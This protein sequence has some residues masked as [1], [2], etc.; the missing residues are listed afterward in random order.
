MENKFENTIILIDGSSFLYRAYY[1]LTPMHS[2]KG[3][4]VQAVFGFCRMIKKIMNTFK[5]HYMALVWDSKGKTVRH[6]LYENYKSTRQAPPSDLFLQKELIQQFADLIS[7]KQIEHPGIEADDLMFSL[8]QDLRKQGYNILLITSDKDMGQMVEGDIIIFDPFK[9]SFIDA[10]KLEEKYGFPISKLVFYFALIGDSSDNIPGVRGIGPKGATD[11]V[12][13]FDSLTDLYNNIEKVPKERTRH[14]LLES[15]DD[16]FLSE[17]LF[18]LHY[19]PQSLVGQDFIF[20]ENKWPQARPLFE[21]LNFKSLLKDLPLPTTAVTEIASTEREFVHGRYHFIT[22]VMHEQLQEI[23]ELFKTHKVCALDTETDSLRALESNLL[24]I[25]VCFQASTAYYIPYGHHNTQQ[26]TKAEVLTALKPFLEDATIQ[27]YFHHA[28]YDQKVLYRAG[29]EVKGITF[30]TLIAASLVTPDWQRIGL[31][32]LSDFYFHE[33][34]LSYEEVVKARG[35]KN[36]AEV[37]LKLATDYAAGDAHQTWQLVPV[38]KK[39]LKEHDQTKLYYEIELPL[40]QVL[41]AM[42][43]EGIILDVSVL[44]KLDEHVSRDLINLRKQIIDLVGEQW[45]DINL[46]SSKQL[47]ELL[48]VYLHLAPVKKTIQKTGY[49]T[50]QEVLKELAKTHPVPSLVVKYRELAKLKNTYIDSLPEYINP[51]TGRIHTTFRQTAVATGRL[52]SFDPNLQNIPTSSPTDIYVRAAF[53]APAG[54]VFLSADYSQI[55]LRVLAYF[56]QDETLIKAFKEN[57]DIHALTATVLFDVPLDQVTHEQRKVAKRINFS[58]LY[59]LTPY[60]LSKDLDIPLSMAR[61]YIDKYM[62]QFPGI[63]KWM[64]QVIEETNQ[65]GYVT[66]YWGRRRYI[67]GIYEKNKSL[68]EAAR[69]IAINTKAQGTAAELMKKGMIDLYAQLQQQ[70]LHTKLVLQIHD[71]LLL[72]VPEN[73]IERVQK[74]V[75]QTLEHVV[76]WNIP[77]VI[78]T[79]IGHDWHEVTK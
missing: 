73:E 70:N 35:Y 76:Q 62:A 3:V 66:T 31:K 23:V 38:L 69:R 53:K 40:I 32:A 20:D 34:M 55:E 5:P 30:D 9:D 4:A 48:F 63:T 75:A 37:P 25:S 2:A 47:E 67:S 7:L 8:A 45:R 42:E 77:L 12:K 21:E 64:D 56:S 36:F 28:K 61:I 18:K 68:Y 41:Y 1:G 57:K 79:R 39:E 43:K 29:I 78:T 71:E 72:A 65:F 51:E 54:S 52:A 10:K 14:L 6:E 26:L 22:V 16:A 27:K 44:K 58:I 11:L 74:L 46:N 17:K 50:D 24:G 19:Y 60:G 13:Q 59:G 15:R 33:P 49:S